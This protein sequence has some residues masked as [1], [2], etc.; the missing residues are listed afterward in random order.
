[1]KESLP[2]DAL[3]LESWRENAAPWIDIVRAGRIAS[4]QQVTDDAIVEAV[5]GLSPR[6]VLDIGCGEGWLAR[7]LDARGIRVVGV[8]AVSELIE[9][10]RGASVG[11]FRT[12]AYEEITAESFGLAFD[13][14]VSNFSLLGG[15]V[16][17]NLLRAVPSLLNEGGTLVVQTLHPV[18]ACGERPYRDGWCAG[19]WRSFGPQ[20]SNPPPWYFRTLARWLQLLRDCGFGHV[21]LREPL[22]PISNLPISAIFIARPSPL[23]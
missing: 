5:C 22:D 19:S 20:F 14:A 8:D 2:N 7:A 10:A 12:L 23:N 17:D 18:T 11:D 16:V 15:S 4:R 6:D 13:V 9:A 3:I 1:M 21:T